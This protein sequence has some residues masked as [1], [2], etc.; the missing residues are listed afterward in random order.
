MLG[1]H[2]DALTAR[3]V[4]IAPGADDRGNGGALTIHTAKVMSEYSFYHKV[5]FIL[6][7]GEENGV[8]G[9]KDYAA[10]HTQH[11]IIGLINNEL[12]PALKMAFMILDPLVLSRIEA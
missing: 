1:A 11:K 7:T 5:R 10:R 4:D 12:I 8:P 2:I 3:G 6:F 9:S